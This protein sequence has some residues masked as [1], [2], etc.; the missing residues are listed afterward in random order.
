MGWDDYEDDWDDEDHKCRC[1]KPATRYCE[2]PFSAEIYNNYDKE[3]M[4]DSCYKSSADD[5]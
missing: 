4:C 1:G 5:I 3:W 2:D